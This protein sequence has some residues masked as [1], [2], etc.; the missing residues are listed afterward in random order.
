MQ[1]NPHLTVV[2]CGLTCILLDDILFSMRE[3][4][5]LMSQLINLREREIKSSP[6]IFMTGPRQSGKT[7]QT[8]KLS[9]HYYNWDTREVKKAFLRDPYF[10]RENT[11]NQW[12]IFDEIHKKRDWKKLLKGYYDSPD[13]S[14][15]FLVTGSGRFNLYQ[16]GGDSLQGRYDL[17]HMLPVSYDEF[18]GKIDLVA[19]RNF[20][21]WIPQAP[22]KTSDLDLIKFGGFPAPLIS[23]SVQKL[24]K[25]KDLYLQRLIEE[26]IRDFS[27]VTM[28]DKVDLLARILPGRIASPLSV[29]SLSEDVE[30]SRDSIQSWLKL[31]D[32][33][34]LG[35]SLPPFS[36][37]IERAVK[38][39]KKWYFYQWAYCEDPGNLFE[40][41]LAV[42]LL[43][44]CTYWR[45]QGLGVYELFY[46]RDQNGREVDFVITKNLKPVALIEAKSSPQDWTNALKHYSQKLNIPGFLIYPQGPTKKGQHGFSMSSAV[47]LR[48][49]LAQ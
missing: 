33:L 36:R 37:R 7:F 47:F 19:E 18:R 24:N 21:N 14:E 39:E 45:D 31:F 10:F 34:Y 17:F 4:P 25:W 11:F 35:F 6:M 27:K 48:G 9:K 38:K 13:R 1:V 22:E 12:V 8:L 43:T 46:I 30:V 28:L 29:K 42:Q 44:V 41:Y 23:Q 26:D 49:L 40:N 20:I 32:T 2:N 16:R 3:I 5:R 15:N